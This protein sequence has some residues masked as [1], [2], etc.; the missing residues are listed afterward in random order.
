MKMECALI[1]MS[2]LKA[3]VISALEVA[4]AV[5]PQNHELRAHLAELLIAANRPDDALQHAL[6]VL[7]DVPDHIGALTVAM[8]ACLQHSPNFSELECIGSVRS[9]QYK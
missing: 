4:I 5:S 1:Y 2:E 6:A 8:Q 3:Q 9:W 7:Q